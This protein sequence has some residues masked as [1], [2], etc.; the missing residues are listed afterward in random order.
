[1]SR[2]PSSS[3]ASRARGAGNRSRPRQEASLPPE[4]SRS[5]EEEE[6][7]A[8]SWMSMFQ[9]S[10]ITQPDLESCRTKYSVPLQY[11]L[12]LP[13]HHMRP[14]LPE[15][16]WAFMYTDAFDAGLRLPL[17]PFVLECLS[18]WGIALPQMVP[19]SWRYVVVFVGE[20]ALHGIRPTLTL[21]HY[22]FL[23]EQAKGL[24]DIKSKRGLRIDK[25]PK[26][27]EGWMRRYCLVRGEEMWPFNHVW[28][29][30]VVPQ[31]IPGL[32]NLEA[33]QVGQLRSI[34]E[35][36]SM[37]KAMDE[38]WLVRAGLS[39]SQEEMF[40]S[41][42]RTLKGKNID[43]GPPGP[44]PGPRA[45]G[46]LRIGGVRSEPRSYPQV[47]PVPATQISSAA[48]VPTRRADEPD[49]RQ[50]KRP[51]G[52]EAGGEGGEMH[53]LK[54]SRREELAVQCSSS[55]TRL[56][57]ADSLPT[58]EGEEISSGWRMMDTAEPWK[59][60]E[61]AMTFVQGVLF[62]KLTKDL[63]TLTSDA[64]VSRSLK[65]IVMGL[66]LSVALVSRVQESGALL[67]ELMESATVDSDVAT[68]FEDE[69]W[70]AEAIKL[71]ARCQNYAIKLLEVQRER[72][73]SQAMVMML[74]QRV[75]TLEM[76]VNVPLD[77]VD[78]SLSTSSSK[79]A[80]ETTK[81]SK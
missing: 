24:Y 41:L 26:P 69:L 42:A 79:D 51:R 38:S 21:F 52:T 59:S 10:E 16:P 18:Y 58:P 76:Q 62:P 75:E 7:L 72:N 68:E 1:M 27:A 31:D 53:L 19:S 55:S 73:E 23:L 22:F 39:P 3:N 45:P 32:S 33:V 77:S 14:Y 56:V 49:S 37:I 36:T 81:P 50:L 57:V 66:H 78:P 2:R 47:T 4:A 35:S 80:T 6:H 25:L 30:I 12:S 54:R 34:L 65:H 15:A 17:H 60:T 74:R 61:E 20:C 5:L 64:L 43:Q 71:R 29:T 46:P 44:P 40:R 28:T 48:T 11:H 67:K 63:C 13:G 70:K 8:I 9:E